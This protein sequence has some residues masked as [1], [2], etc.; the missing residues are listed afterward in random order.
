M[1]FNLEWFLQNYPCFN[2]FSKFSYNR[3]CH[4]FVRIP[5]KIRK[6]KKKVVAM[7]FRWQLPLPTATS[8]LAFHAFRNSLDIHG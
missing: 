3:K 7:T 6:S 2:S 1:K 5:I 8:T 4:Y